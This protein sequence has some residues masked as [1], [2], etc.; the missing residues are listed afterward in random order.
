M[1]P[2]Q[3]RVY[4]AA[5]GAVRKADPTADR[6]ELHRRAF[7]GRDKSSKDF[8]TT[9]DFDRILEVFESISKP[10]NLNAQL[11]QHR[12]QEKRIVHA[13]YNHLQLLTALFASQGST[14]DPPVPAG[15]PPGGP[16]SSARARAEKY[17]ETI[18]Q[19]RFKVQRANQLSAKPTYGEDQERKA[20]PLTQYVY[21][22]TRC[23]DSLRQKKSWTQHDLYTRAGLACPCLACRQNLS[24][25]PESTPAP[26][27]PILTESNQPF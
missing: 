16:P 11:R 17:L 1:T 24:R 5:W 18:L 4:W 26:A 23:I 19:N 7:N 12:Q 14:G 22:I 10:N 27:E 13:G 21:T 3:T 25:H 15:D 8:N 20:S 9:T 6:H 2:K